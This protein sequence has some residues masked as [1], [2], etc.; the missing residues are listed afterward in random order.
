MKKVRIAIW[1]IS[2]G[3]LNA[4]T[5]EIN[6]FNTEIVLFFDNDETKHG[7]CYR[8]IPIM[9]ASKQLVCEK[10]VDYILVTALSA[11]EGIKEQLID[12]GIEKEKIQVF[13]AKDIK[14]YCVGNI[15]DIDINLIKKIYFEPQKIINIVTEYRTIFDIY[16]K[17]PACEER[18]EEW[19]NK[20]KMIS[21]ACG[22][23]VNGKRMMYS[24]SKEAFEY[25]V[26]KKF[27]LIECDLTRLYNGE[28]VLLH[29][30][31]R[32]W[33][34]EEEQYSMMTAKD[35]FMLLKGH[36]EM[37][38]L[39]DTKWRDYDEYCLLVNEIDRLIETICDDSNE[40]DALKEQVIMEVYDEETIKIA[41]EKDFNMIF[42]Q[43]RNPQWPYFMNTV[44]LCHKYGVKVIA[45]PVYVCLEW[46]K[47]IRIFTDKNIKIFAF[48]TDSIDEYSALRRMNVTG[49][50]TNYLTECELTGK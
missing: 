31:E 10:A 8:N 22:G 48:S 33:E 3:I 5:E 47:L 16:S 18:V 24:N 2:D 4:I 29:D 19:Y 9:P 35:L 13:V 7:I 12:M 17:I 39:I 43:Y 6:P 23:I 36:R 40:R 14:R 15:D 11:Y 21:H 46:K 49:I 27:K 1:G 26:K 20:G 44:M 37:S 25:S 50:F 30:W 45:M 41:K 34:L 38:C 42:T 32:C 28:L